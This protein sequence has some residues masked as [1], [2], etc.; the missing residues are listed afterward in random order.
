VTLLHIVDPAEWDGGT[1]QP[2]DE[3]FV[4]LSY[5]HQVHVPGNLFYAGRRGLRLL[6]V[7]EP[8]VAADVRVEGGF[9]HLYAPL[10][11]DVVLGDL[12]FE[13]DDDGV[14]QPLSAPGR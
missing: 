1:I 14:F 10:T 3:G 9:P 4:H 8:R 13:P 2:G 7:D 12:P 5:D 6:V 11:P